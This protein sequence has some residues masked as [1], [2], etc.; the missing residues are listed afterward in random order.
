MP[1]YASCQRLN[2]SVPNDWQRTHL[3]V[4]YKKITLISHKLGTWIVLVARWMIGRHINLHRITSLGICTMLCL[5]YNR[6]ANHYD[7]IMESLLRIS[8]RRCC[9]SPLPRSL[10]IC[11]SVCLCRLSV[12]LLG[13]R[14][15]QLIPTG[16][17]YS[18]TFRTSSAAS[19]CTDGCNI[20]RNF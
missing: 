5:T 14:P 3:D 10:F 11:I 16:N 20:F 12:R 6:K 17:S 8:S 15:Q 13:F 4:E 2:R 18:L 9:L 7:C 1:F 19:L